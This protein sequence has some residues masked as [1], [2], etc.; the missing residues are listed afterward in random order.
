[1]KARIYKLTEYL[2]RVENH[3]AIEELRQQPNSFV[4]LHLRLLRLRIRKA[5]ARAM[6]HVV[7]PHRR[8]RAALVCRDLQAA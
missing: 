5:L 4:L 1:M 2:Q 7:N 6:R 3:L 8:A